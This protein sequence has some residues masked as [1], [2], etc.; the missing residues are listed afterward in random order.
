MEDV[1]AR[2]DADVPWTGPG[3]G[4]HA[5]DAGGTTQA[6]DPYS[7]QQSVAYAIHHSNQQHYHSAQNHFHQHHHPQTQSP[8]GYYPYQYQSHQHAHHHYQ[9]STTGTTLTGGTTGTTSLASS[10][11]YSLPSSTISTPRT[12]MS[13][14]D[15]CNAEDECLSYSDMPP[16]ALDPDVQT[17]AEALGALAGSGGTLPEIEISRPAPPPPPQHFMQRVSNIPIVR[18]SINSVSYAYE[19]TKNVSYVYSAETVETGVKTI[20]KPVLNTLEP[21]LTPLDRFACNQLDRVVSGVGANLG[22]MVIS[23]D[24]MRGLKYC[25]QWLEYAT[26]HIDRQIALLRDFLLR[27]TGNVTARIMGPQSADGTSSPASLPTP[28]TTSTITPP[29]SPVHPAAADDSNA[30]GSSSHA[31]ENLAVSS[32]VFDLPSALLAIR[33]EIVE[34]LRKVVDVL[35]RYAAVYLPPPAR[36]TVREFILSLPNRWATLQ[37]QPPN[38]PAPSAPTSS[39]APQKSAPPPLNTSSSSTATLN[40]DDVTSATSPPAGTPPE[41]HRVLTLAAE[42]S[43]MLKG[44]MNVFSQTVDGAEMVLGRVVHPHPF[45]ADDMASGASSSASSAPRPVDANGD[46]TSPAPNR[47][48]RNS[49][50]STLSSTSGLTLRAR[51][52]S[53]GSE[54]S[55]PPGPCMCP[56]CVGGVGDG[57]ER[58]VQIDGRSAMSYEAGL[59]EGM[60]MEQEE[61]RRGSSPEGMDMDE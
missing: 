28:A 50:S 11:S 24:T 48:R 25:L 27:A 32:N 33:R 13:I 44:V 42:S 6:G 19:A 47:S 46:A 8:A 57:F 41:A 10:L 60:E 18:E 52:G 40:G 59:R 54:T 31:P 12:S 35:G 39:L 7:Q 53:I 58:Q 55:G 26:N 37:T 22:A 15:L 4:A 16:F 49:G 56:A 34:T 21:A 36:R 2:A 43:N 30:S 38:A 20:S 17:A 9:H 45:T 51:G 5:V 61:V 14:S 23:D 29:L 3:P 1:N